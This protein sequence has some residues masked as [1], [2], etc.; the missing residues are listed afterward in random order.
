MSRRV[1]ALVFGGRSVEHEVSLVSA[2]G[3]YDNLDRA[4]NEIV[5]VGVDREG[6]PRVGGE[7]LLDGG[8]ARGAG[9][10]VRWPSHRGDRTL[11]EEAIGRALTPPLDAVFPIVHGSGGEDG[12]LQGVLALAG[13][14][15]V[16]AGVLGSSLA[17][18]KDR[19]RRVLERAGIPV[20]RDAVF[21]GPEAG[22]AERVR[23]AAEALG[24]PV[25]VKPARAGSSVGIAKV[26]DAAALPAAVAAARAVD[27]KIVIER[28]VPAAREVEVAVLGL[29]RPEASVVGEIVPGAEFYDYDAKYNDPGSQLLVPAPLDPGLAEGL[30]AHAV[31]AFRELDLA[32]LARVDFLLS[33]ETGEV[34][35]NE[36]NTLPGFT[37][38]SMYPR[39]WEASGVPYR[40]LLERLIEL[41]LEAAA[42]HPLAMAAAARGRLTKP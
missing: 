1:V 37:P 35:L 15:C 7:E 38:I 26:S 23:A 40:E 16:G 20:V 14:P 8:L 31:R 9:A 24:W 39:L 42:A 6:R 5:L 3:I 33:R 11:R 34:V 18:D 28:A 13:I 12:T 25:F 36:V 29:W 21:E 41:A 32:G 10:V 22:D 30:R 19:T 4:R 27:P 17:M 2:R